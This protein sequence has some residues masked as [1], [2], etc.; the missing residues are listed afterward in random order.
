MKLISAIF[1]A[2]FMI[3]NSIHADEPIALNFDLLRDS[4]FLHQIVGQKVK[5][6][7]FLFPLD[8]NLSILSSEP[9]LKTCCIGSQDK[10]D[11]QIFLIGDFE[12]VPRGQRV[13]F[14]GVFS[15]D[16]MEENTTYRLLHPQFRENQKNV[17][18]IFLFLM[19]GILWI[20]AYIC[21]R[22]FSISAHSR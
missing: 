12:K 9:H 14:E 1:L 7:G 11:Q 21:R 8:S 5:I 18:V 6:R 16:Q 3:V 4:A 19:G 2:F 20:G 15:I 22:L 13:E 17:S 10:S